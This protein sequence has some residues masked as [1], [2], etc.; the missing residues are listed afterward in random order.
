MSHR[1]GAPPSADV[2]FESPVPASSSSVG[3]SAE[4]GVTATQEVLP[5][6]RT[7]SA[8]GAGEEPRV[9]CSTTRTRT[10]CHCPISDTLSG[11]RSG[12]GGR[13]PQ[14]SSQCPSSARSRAHITSKSAWASSTS[15]A[16]RGLKTHDDKNS[17]VRSVVAVTVADRGLP[18]ISAISP[19]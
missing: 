2:T 3:T 8:P 10:P 12:S 11:S 6:T 5:P 7:K 18:S 14:Q 16:S 1:Y 4:P 13:P 17:V 9:P 19:K 15:S